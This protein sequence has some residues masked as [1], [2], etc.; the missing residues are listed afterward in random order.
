M[1]TKKPITRPELDALIKRAR[2]RDRRL[3]PFLRMERENLIPLIGTLYVD[4]KLLMLIVV[5]AELLNSRG[6]TVTET[7]AAA[8]WKAIVAEG[9]GS[10][11]DARYRGR[12]PE[13]EA[14]QSEE[15]SASPADVVRAVPPVVPAHSPPGISVDER[16]DPADR[17]G[18]DIKFG[19]DD[20]GQRKLREL[21]AKRRDTERLLPPILKH[22]RM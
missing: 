14:D 7:T 19:R 20:Q 1:G 4:R 5:E 9:P 18:D 12:H 13:S 21:R 22:K 11:R 3:G 2:K 15:R 10:S 17:S 8:T 6:R 16:A